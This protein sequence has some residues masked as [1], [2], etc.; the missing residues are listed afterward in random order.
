LKTKRRDPV[1]VNLGRPGV[2]RVGQGPYG[3][4]KRGFKSARLRRLHRGCARFVNEWSTGS[5][6]ANRA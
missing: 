5:G 4:G 1:C 2:S 6:A 3:A